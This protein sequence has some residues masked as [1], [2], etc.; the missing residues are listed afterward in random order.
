MQHQNITDNDNKGWRKG[1]YHGAADGFEST[2]L[3]LHKISSGH[4]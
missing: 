1:K 4:F 2:S 3:S